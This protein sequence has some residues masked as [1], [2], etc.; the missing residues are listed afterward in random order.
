MLFVTLEHV[1]NHI[2]F[3]IISI[4]ITI[5]LITLLVRELGELRD[6]LEKWNDCY[7]FSL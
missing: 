3:S 6:L 2:S 1:L 5:H 4:V 7:F